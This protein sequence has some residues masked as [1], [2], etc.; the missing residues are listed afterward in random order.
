MAPK[1]KKT[2]RYPGPGYDETAPGNPSKKAST[3][4]SPAPMSA[5]AKAKA[6]ARGNIQNII[7]QP[8]KMNKAN[9]SMKLTKTNLDKTARGPK[10]GTSTVASIAKRFGITAREARDV[11]T[12]VSTTARMAPLAQTGMPVKKTFK[13]IKKQI[14][15]VGTAATKGKKGTTPYLVKANPYSAAQVKKTGKGRVSADVFK[16]KKR[17]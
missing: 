15:E 12:A 3:K 1:P 17:K 2:G 10:A 6:S 11:V 14:K 16:P 9:P 13:N 8:R 4:Y 7:T 5:K